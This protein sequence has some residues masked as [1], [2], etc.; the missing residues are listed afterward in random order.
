MGLDQYAYAVAHEG[1]EQEQL[2]T[3]RKHNR[4]HGWMEQLWEDKGRPD[5]D[6]SSKEVSFPH[7]R[8]IR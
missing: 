2:T 6:L 7:R 1:A 5:W 4:L 3:W 8:S